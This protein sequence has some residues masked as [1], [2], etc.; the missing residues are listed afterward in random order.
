M[1]QTSTC[2]SSSAASTTALLRRGSEPTT[3]PQVNTSYDGTH[4]VFRLLRLE[5]W[6]PALMNLGYYPFTGP[7]ASWNV[8]VNLELAQRQL[9][10]KS[11]ALL[12]IQAQHDV[13]D[14]A[15]GR[16][17]SSFIMHCLT[18]EANIVG[19]DLL[20]HNIH[21]AKTLFD[22]LPNLS[23]VPGDACNIPFPNAAFDRLHCLEAAFHFPDRAQFL[24]EAYRVLRPGGRMVLVDF[25]WRTDADRAHREHPHTLLVR[26]VWQ[27]E[28]FNTIAEYKQQAI[29]AGFQISSQRDWTTR[30]A[31]PIQAVFRVLSTL[32]NHR[33]GRRFL[34]WRNPLYRSI[35][36]DDW[37]A[38]ATAVQAHQ[39]VRDRSRYMAFVLD[40]PL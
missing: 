9:V 32:G 25:A 20:P 4:V 7:L 19:M 24:R 27:W 15:C 31:T 21:V 23:Y 35:S 36:H 18:P 3:P 6:G 16:G 10:M 26:D 33:W 22:K 30:V 2:L 14:V 40:K 1:S 37:Q 28:D 5:T 8:L 11:L 34:E 38:I 17:K 39:F 29:A 12:E 13:L